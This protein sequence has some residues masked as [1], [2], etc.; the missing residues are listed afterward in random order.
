MG[1][2][3]PRVLYGGSRRNLPEDRYFSRDADT[4]RLR[5]DCPF[6]LDGEFFNPDA[7]RDL[8]LSSNERARFIRL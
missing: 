4:V 5:M 3:A 2:Y 7:G 1:Y 6:T 8:I